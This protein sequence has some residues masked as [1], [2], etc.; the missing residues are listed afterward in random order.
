MSPKRRQQ[1]FVPARPRSEV[2]IA[3]AV[4]ASIVIVTVALVWLIRPGTPGVPGGGGLFNRQPRATILVVVTAGVLALLTR[5][6]LVGRRRPTRFGP[7]GSVAIGAAGVIVLA[8]LAGVFWPGGL[9]RHW[10]KQPKTTPLPPVASTTTPV[11]P[12]TGASTTQ[13][14]ATTASTAT[15]VAPATS[16]TVASPT[17]KAR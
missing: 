3:A 8:V 17:T 16:S 6:L 11:A 10:P 2:V 15:T 14:S 7:R 1:Q 9:V 12:T 5:W 13:P 4:G